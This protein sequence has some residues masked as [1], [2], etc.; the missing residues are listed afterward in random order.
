MRKVCMLIVVLGLST[1]VS[2]S[3]AGDRHF[4]VGVENIDHYPHYTLQNGEWSGFGRDV[5][6]AF[7]KDRGYSFTYRPYPVKRLMLKSWQEEVDLMFPDNPLWFPE[8]KKAVAITYSVNFVEVVEGTLVPP[9]R[10]GD[11]INAITI[12]GTITGFTAASYTPYIEKGQVKIDHARDSRYVLLKV[13]D[14]RTDAAF[15]AVDSAKYV[16]D[17]VLNTPGSLVF[18]PSLPYDNY[19]NYV[20]SVKRP[21]L[22]KEFDQFVEQHAA[23]IAELKQKY[24][25][26]SGLQ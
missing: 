3:L 6:D 16:L 18:D 14:G 2:T 11:G 10:V 8:K 5:L 20:S 19:A 24:K 13:L 17:G 25:M 12:L 22:I 21:H 26:T 15:M 4:V 23:F 9:E 7:A 1:G